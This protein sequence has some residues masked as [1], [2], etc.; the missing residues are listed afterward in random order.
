MLLPEDLGLAVL[1]HPRAMRY[2]LLEQDELARISP[3][4]LLDDGAPLLFT[5]RIGPATA[6]VFTTPLDPKATDLVMRSAFPPL[7]Y[8]LIKESS[9]KSEPTRNYT[10]GDLFIADA[11]DSGAA[12]WIM[13][14]T[15]V[16]LGFA[17]PVATRLIVSPLGKAANSC[18][19]FCSL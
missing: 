18:R 10:C 8:R 14:F 13:R 6:Y 1:G 17:M 12:L 19:D 3:C 4:L 7:L 15:S 2:F 16:L 5:C 9:T 11:E